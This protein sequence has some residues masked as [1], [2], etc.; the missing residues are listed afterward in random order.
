MTASAKSGR[1][2]P[3]ERTT[4]VPSMATGHPGQITARVLSNAA[5]GPDPER[6]AVPTRLPRMEAAV[7]REKPQTPSPAKRCT[8]VPLTAAGPIGANTMGAR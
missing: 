7:A 1:P 3:A 5:Q 8:I 4:S 6:G 2:S